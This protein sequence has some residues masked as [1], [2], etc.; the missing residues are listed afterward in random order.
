MSGTQLLALSKGTG[1]VLA[2][3]GALFL[4]V[5][6]IA[7]FASRKEKA[8]Q[9]RPPAAMRPGPSDQELE[10][11][12]LGRF[13]GWGL[14]MVM[15]LVLWIPIYFLR[16]PSQNAAQAAQMKQESITR[17]ELLTQ[18]YGPANP[19]GVGCQRCHGL[20][21]EGQAILYNGQVAHSANLTQI[22]AVYTVDEI[23]GIIDKGVPNT[24]MPSWSIN[25]Q[26]ALDDQQIQDIINYLMT[27]QN[28]PKDQ[29]KCLNPSPSPS[30]TASSSPSAGA[31]AVATTGASPSASPGGK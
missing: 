14:V 7:I 26:G 16:E 2:G 25:Y 28:V 31:S 8:T 27:I 5:A 6:A 9:L 20:N 3:I 21:L 11:T 13:Q 23:R 10:G 4:L 19:T 30:A 18:L 15:I 24:A 22:C 29:N 12:M 1:A 17:G